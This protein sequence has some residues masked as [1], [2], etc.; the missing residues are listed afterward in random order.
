MFSSLSEFTNFIHLGGM[1]TVTL[2]KSFDTI[3]TFKL[4]SLLSKN[5]ALLALSK[6]P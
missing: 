2:Y 6:R 5:T 3:S 4:N 1:L